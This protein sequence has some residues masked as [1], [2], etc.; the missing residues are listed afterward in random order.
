G[1]GTGDARGSGAGD[2]RGPLAPF[3][4][5]GGGDVGFMGVRDG[6]QGGRAVDSVVF[7]CD[8]SGSMINTFSSLKDQLTHS[9]EGLKSVQSFNVVF[10]QGEKCSAFAGGLLFATPDNKRKAFKWLEEQT[11]T[12]T[13]N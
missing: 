5:S 13:T 2:G 3:G 9:I 11:T 1:A 10:F 4:A 7:V 8:A 6:G 12:G